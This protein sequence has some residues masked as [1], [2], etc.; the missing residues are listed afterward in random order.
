MDVHAA[1]ELLQTAGVDPVV[2]A[3]AV[4][5]VKGF[6]DARQLDAFCQVSQEHPAVLDPQGRLCDPAAA[7]ISCALAWSPG[8]ASARLDLA[9][10]LA[11]DL[12]QVLAALRAGLIDLARAR[13][14]SLGTSGLNPCDRARLAEAA[15]DWAP[16]HT[17]GQLR[18]WLARQVARID[19]EAV[20]RRR[21]KARRARRVWVSAE[22]DEMATLGAYLSAEEAQAVLA[23]L[24]AGIANQQ[25]SVDTARA[26]LLV[27]RLTGI[28]PADPVPVQVIIT[29]DGPE[30][31][32]HG[33][34]SA[35]HADRLRQQHCQAPTATLL[36]PPAGSDSYRPSPALTRYA[37][38]RDRHCRFPGCRRPATQC[39]LDHL[40]PWPAG[41]TD[42]RNI[43]CLC[44]YH[45][46][47]KTHTSWQ[48]TSRPGHVLEWTSPRGHTYT[49]TLHDP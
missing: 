44:R 30:L 7:E 17:L 15:C 21:A 8:N 39:D 28:S 4:E 16:G 45:H 24:N 1:W 43:A 9:I 5:V 33:P 38:A 41:P 42:H 14:I 29:A 32:G 37:K 3:R 6:A 40:I 35:A 31:A 22:P 27:E 25:G 23:S 34:I 19:S 11:E 10:G 18:A 20:R 26:D 49:T 47:V 12:P 13:E 36:H 48:V 46:R 2:V